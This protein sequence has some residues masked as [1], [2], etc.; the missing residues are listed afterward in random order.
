MKF[1]ITLFIA[2]FFSMSPVKAT[3][4]IVDAIT[5]NGAESQDN[6][7]NEDSESIEASNL[8][9]DA[10][11]DG[12]FDS[13]TKQYE[14]LIANI[15]YESEFISHAMVT[16]VVLF[17]TF[18]LLWVVQRLGYKLRDRL[19]LIRDQYTVYHDRFRY[20]ARAIR[21]TG[22]FIVSIF[23][24]YTL[25]IVWG[26]TEM[27]L[28]IDEWG[29]AL[30]G[31]V[32]SIFIVVLIAF[33]IWESINTVLEKYIDSLDSVQSS[34]LITV[35]PIIKNIIFIVFI[36]LFSLV[37]LSQ[38]GI[39][40]LPLLAGAGVL[41]I[42]VG[43]GAQTMVKDFLTGFTIILEDLIQ[44]GD[45]AT[46]AGKTGVIERI[47]IRKVQMRDLSGVVFT[48]P[49]GEI[50]IVENMTKEYS[51]YMF[52]IGVAYRENT[53]NV[54]E[55]L[56]EIDED[57]RADDDFKDLI[58]EPIEILGVD[59]FA[60]S[61]VVIKARVKTRPIKQWAVG[62]EFNRRIK[63]KFDEKG[64]EIP[65][66]HQTIYF[67]EDKQG[68]A[69]A[70]HVMLSKKS[71]AQSGGKKPKKEATKKSTDQSQGDQVGYEK[72]SQHAEREDAKEK[73]KSK[74]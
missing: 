58:L 51:F 27:N 43:F 44:V 56:R 20:Y 7:K 19:N 54:I 15:G 74:S 1:F 53:D 50:T 68:K 55:Y 63:I 5:N 69:P 26:V 36:I 45:V 18:L 49:F 39:N 21:Y 59:A 10:N 24:I 11:L 40:I 9:L 2:I 31:E 70:A 65:F 22:Y 23:S 6:G 57:I 52:D 48:I 16:T 73:A 32:L 61:S 34:R 41:G 8:D 30:I 29:R 4:Q 35:L 66:P 28:V 42:A 37:V 46:L 25:F 60:D 47:T 67:G 17:I 62:R 33:G 3:S 72:D 13:M 71:K 14:E 12:F 64:V 38:I